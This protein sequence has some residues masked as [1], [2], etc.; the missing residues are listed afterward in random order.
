MRMYWKLCVLLMSYFHTLFHMLRSS[1]KKK[2]QKSDDLIELVTEE[3]QSHSQ[4]PR[5]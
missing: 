5:K 1:L 2:I 3:T 4:S